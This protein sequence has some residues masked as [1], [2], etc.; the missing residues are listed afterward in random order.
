MKK[1]FLILLLTAGLAIIGG[2][3]GLDCPLNN[4]VFATWTFYNSDGTQQV[5]LKDTL[6]VKAEGTDSILINRLY[7]ATSIQL[8]MSY[9]EDADKLLFEI[10]SIDTLWYADTTT[11]DKPVYH[12]KVT[13]DGKEEDA[14]Y[15]LDYPVYQEWITVEKTNQPYFN[16]PECGVWV[17]HYVT[18]V[19]STN[20]LIDSIQVVNP[21]IDN[22]EQEN[23]RICFRTE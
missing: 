15:L 1:S 21:K 22:N 6:Y 8:P 10:H 2:C 14:W 12:V 20:H 17:E 9:Y 18:R 4:T 16:S 11:T 13:V 23:F 7:G 5:G 19:S 3:S